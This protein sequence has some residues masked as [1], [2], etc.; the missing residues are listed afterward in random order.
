[1]SK[2]RWT[3]WA[4]SN[5]C[6]LLCFPFASSTF[7]FRLELNGHMFISMTPRAEQWTT[8]K[9]KSNALRI[10][11]KIIRKVIR[12]LEHN[13]GVKFWLDLNNWQVFLTRQ[14]LLFFFFFFFSKMPCRSM[15]LCSLILF[16]ESTDVCYLPVDHSFFQFFLFFPVISLKISTFFFF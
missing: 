11:L 16:L 14:L 12:F 6:F 9:K 3:R 7:V 13:V 8:H 4:I 2:W 1:M 15:K 10:Y 5:L